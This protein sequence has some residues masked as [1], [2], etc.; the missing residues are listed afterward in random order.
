MN[1]QYKMA[2]EEAEDL[3]KMMA[4][5]AGKVLADEAEKCKLKSCS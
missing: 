2:V 4:E 5:E 3:R 1:D